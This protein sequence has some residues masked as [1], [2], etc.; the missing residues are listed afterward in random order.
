MEFVVVHSLQF[1]FH[2]V[3]KSTHALPEVPKSS[4]MVFR[5]AGLSGALS[6]NEPQYFLEVTG[7]KPLFLTAF[8]QEGA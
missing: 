2:E 7:V 3:M 5:R 1:T 8:A 6:R 4:R